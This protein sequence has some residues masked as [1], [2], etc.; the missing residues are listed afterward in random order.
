MSSFLHKK[1]D[2]IVLDSRG[3]VSFYDI[4]KNR[5]AKNSSIIRIS[6]L[7]NSTDLEKVRFEEFYNDYIQGFIFGYRYNPMDISS[8]LYLGSCEIVYIHRLDV[9]NVN[10]CI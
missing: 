4:R 3:E 5:R 9:V 7:S 1:L 6:N 10:D 8:R 2:T